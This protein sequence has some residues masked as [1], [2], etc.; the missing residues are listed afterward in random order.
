MLT[1]DIIPSHKVAQWLLSHIHRFLNWFG[2]EKDRVTEEFLYT[3]I[4]VIAALFIGWAIGNLVRMI[5][6]ES[7]SART[8]TRTGA[9]TCDSPLLSHHPSSC[10]TRATAFCIYRT[11]HNQ[12]YNNARATHIHLYSSVHGNMLSLLIHVGSS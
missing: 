5:V 4:I 3:A 9:E 1:A 2:L 10:H 6:R 8:G 12:Y 7:T 11:L